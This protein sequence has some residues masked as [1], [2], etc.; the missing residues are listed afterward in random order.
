M[1]GLSG[2]SVPVLDKVEETWSWGRQ[3]ARSGRGARLRLAGC[4]SHRPY[5]CAHQY[6][7][8]PQS[9]RCQAVQG[10][11]SRGA[12]R[13]APPGAIPGFGGARA[14]GAIPPTRE[15]RA[16]GLIP[17]PG[18]LRA[19][20]R[21]PDSTPDPQIPRSG[22]PPRTQ[23]CPVCRSPSRSRDARCAGARLEDGNARWGGIYPRIQGCRRAG[24]LPTLSRWQHTSLRRLARFAGSP[25]AVS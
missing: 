16:P 20:A 11:A 13:M 3:S 19:G 5:P 2:M 22:A 14:R 23:G 10:A 18:S 7:P 6:Q 21:R 17:Q 24:G 25:M 15:V 4:G 9:S 8:P 1:T 12:N